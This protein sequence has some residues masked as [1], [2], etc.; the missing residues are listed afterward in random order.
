MP[1]ISQFLGIIISMYYDDHAPPHFHVK[2]AEYRAKVDIAT[3]EIQE[4]QLPRRVFPLVLEWAAL[5]RSELWANWERA[6]A[7]LPLEMIE[8]LE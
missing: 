2:Y 7:G 3:L 1:R 6:R 5:R 4:G 8:P